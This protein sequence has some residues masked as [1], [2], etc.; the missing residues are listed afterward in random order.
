[1]INDI[2]EVVVAVITVMLCVLVALAEFAI[3]IAVVWAI[4]RWL[5]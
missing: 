4:V 5:V 3:P 2:I 1:M